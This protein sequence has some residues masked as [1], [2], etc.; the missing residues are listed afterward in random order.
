MTL[1]LLEGQPVLGKKHGTQDPPGLNLLP[2]PQEV[3]R[4]PT[5]LLG[6]LQGSNEITTLRSLNF[7]QVKSLLSF[8]EGI[9]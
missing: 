6:M 5:C 7:K 2:I 4:I 9:K 3:L 8:T 1:N